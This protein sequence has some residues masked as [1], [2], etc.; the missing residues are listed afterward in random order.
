VSRKARWVTV[1]ERIAALG[2]EQNSVVGNQLAWIVGAR[3]RDAWMA[4]N[5][6]PPDLELRRKTCGTG[7]HCFAI[8]PPPWAAVIDDMID[9]T[10]ADIEADRARQLTLPG[11]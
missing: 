9:V 4:A 2:Y 10:A 11:F 3:A 8:Y 1:P 7:S 5:E 6:S